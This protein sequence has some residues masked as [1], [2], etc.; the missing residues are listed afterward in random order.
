[1]GPLILILKGWEMAFAFQHE[2]CLKISCEFR[3]EVENS[4]GSEQS[5]LQSGLGGDLPRRRAPRHTQGRVWAG[6]SRAEGPHHALTGARSGIRGQH[7]AQRASHSP[8]VRRHDA[9]GS[10]ARPGPSVPAG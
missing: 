6:V 4:S 9:W 7:L 10:E 3:P 5:S 2:M 1:M 8:R